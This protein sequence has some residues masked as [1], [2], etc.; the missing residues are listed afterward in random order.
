MRGDRLNKILI[1]SFLVIGLITYNLWF[2]LGKDWFFALIPLIMFIASIFMYV[3]SKGQSKRFAF[4]AMVSIFS[5]IMDEWLNHITPLRDI[6]D[7]T[8]FEWNDYLL[9]LIASPLTYVPK[10]NGRFQE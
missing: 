6:F 2:F 1:I 9:T 10:F 3:N 5:T 8:K 4:V 7:P